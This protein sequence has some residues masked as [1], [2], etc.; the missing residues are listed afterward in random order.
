MHI[1]RVESSLSSN[2]HHGDVLRRFFRLH[3]CVKHVLPTCI[4]VNICFTV[5]ILILYGAKITLNGYFL[6]VF[7][8][9]A[10]NN[11]NLLGYMQVHNTFDNAKA[12]STV[13]LTDFTN[14]GGSL[15]TRHLDN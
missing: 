7:V 3:V 14:L 11:L 8:S 2:F 12:L 6:S 13:R 4:K 15:L 9:I 5:F 10:Q 1:P